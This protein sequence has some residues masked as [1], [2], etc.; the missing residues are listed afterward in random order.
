MRQVPE[1]LDEL[2]AAYAYPD[3]RPWLRANMVASID[4]AA[5]VAGLSGGLGGAADR[6][7]FH[8]LRGLADVIIVGA[9]TVRAEDYGP[10][11]PGE[12]WERLREGRPAVPPLAIVSGRLD[13]DLDKSIFTQAQ[14]PTIVITSSSAPSVRRKAVAERAELIVAG[15]IGVDFEIAT[16]ELVSRGHRRMHCEGGPGILAQITA[17]GLLDEL[18]LTVSPLLAA[19]DGKRPL[20]GAAL[21]EPQRMRLSG[22]LTDEDFLFLRYTRP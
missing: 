11:K 5:T 6:R 12:G 10:V 21:P 13:L 9:Q 16:A 15:D 17:A 4:G 2:A 20:S 3:D 19:G 8:L 1:G 7:I 14:V 18:C 22:A